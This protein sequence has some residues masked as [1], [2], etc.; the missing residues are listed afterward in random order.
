M[1]Y[2]VKLLHLVQSVNYCIAAWHLHLK[3]IFGY[4]NLPTYQMYQSFRLSLSYDY[5]FFRF[6]SSNYVRKYFVAY[7]KKFKEN[8]VGINSCVTVEVIQEMRLLYFHGFF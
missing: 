6:V 8:F 7:Y 4:D 3:Y 2:Y 1:S 5:H